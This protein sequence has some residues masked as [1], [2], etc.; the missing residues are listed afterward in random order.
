MDTHQ[1]TKLDPLFEKPNTIWRI[2]NNVRVPV[3]RDESV[4][5]VDLRDPINR[6]AHYGTGPDRHDLL[7][8]SESCEEILIRGW[9]VDSIRNTFSCEKAKIGLCKCGVYSALPD[10]IRMD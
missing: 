10:R 6:P 3:A 8:G 5:I 2:S 7:C 9:S 4:D 1:R